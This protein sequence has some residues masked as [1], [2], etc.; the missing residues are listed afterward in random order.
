VPFVSDGEY[1][2]FIRATSSCIRVAVQKPTNNGTLMS[3]VR[4][5]DLHCPHSNTEEGATFLAELLV[6]LHNCSFFTNGHQFC[7]VIP[8]NLWSHCSQS[9]KIVAGLAIFS[10]DGEL[11]SVDDAHQ[12]TGTHQEQRCCWIGFGT[13]Q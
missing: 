8:A 3:S 11:L 4:E 6:E 12:A 9:T 5:F 13:E 7:M 1:L 10:M 2:Y